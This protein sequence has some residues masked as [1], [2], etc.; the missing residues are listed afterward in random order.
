MSLSCRS[1][2]IQTDILWK[3]RVAAKTSVSVSADC[4]LIGT[5][6]TDEDDSN[7]AFAFSSKNNKLRV[8]GFCRSDGEE[9]KITRV[10]WDGKVLSF[11]ARMPS[12][13]AVTKNVFRIRPDGKLDFELTTYEVWKKSDVKPGE[14]PKAWRAARATPYTHVRRIR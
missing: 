9:F 2:K 12:T 4:A 6:I 1:L 7:A 13:E 11:V 8:Y 10:K 5:W 14:I 3:K